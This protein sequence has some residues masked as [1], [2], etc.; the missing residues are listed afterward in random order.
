MHVKYNVATVALCQHFIRNTRHMHG[1]T[2]INVS[3]RLWRRTTLAF[4]QLQFYDLKCRNNFCKDVL[5]LEV[6]FRL[7]QSMLLWP[8]DCLLSS[9]NSI[10]S[11][12]KQNFC[13][14]IY[15]LWLEYAFNQL[16]YFLKV[17]QF[18]FGPNELLSTNDLNSS[19]SGKFWYKGFLFGR[20]F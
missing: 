12:T 19:S 13:K 17:I 15:V 4:L 11:I 18:M 5:W 6:W 1:K 20:T 7:S 10:F 3:R 16:T 2:S 9:F 14:N 8:N